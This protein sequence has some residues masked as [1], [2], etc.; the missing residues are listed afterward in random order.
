[1]GKKI[2]I[3]SDNNTGGAGVVAA[4]SKRALEEAGFICDFFFASQFFKFNP[5]RYL[6]NHKAQVLLRNKLN[7]YKPDFI[8]LHNYDNLFSPSILFELKK[9]KHRNSTPIIMTLHDY[10]V[11]SASNSLT[12][13]EKSKKMF[14]NELPNL[15][16]LLSKKLDKRSYIHGLARILQWYIY[17][18]IFKLD[19]EIDVFLCPSKFI[20]GFLIERIGKNKALFLPNPCRVDYKPIRKQLDVI[21]VTFAGKL[22]YEKG[23]Y[24]FLK[25]I[26]G[27]KSRKL[28]N[29]NIAGEGEYYDLVKSL[30]Y[31][32][33]KNKKLNVNINVLGRVNKEKL[34]DLLDIS[35]FILLPSLCYENSPLT[36][37]EGAYRS[38]RII[39]MNYGGMKEIGNNISGS[40]LLDRIDKD[41]VRTMLD[42]I[43]SRDD[44]SFTHNEKDMKFL[45]LYS[46]NLYSL[47]LFEVLRSKGNFNLAEK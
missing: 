21:N 26:E 12:Y 14:F 9:Y 8:M 22:Y 5:I 11:V 19:K 31:I 1:M 24:E 39:T 29:I 20:E 3:L 17:Y 42:E 15:Y 36:L 23:I 47:K 44:T 4:E 43:T 38:C 46:S 45:N 25:A 27:Y 40:I 34:I 10:H 37:I 33:N 30:A 28:I 32:I 35:H 6:Y 41:S 2:L 16:T 18:K 13:F 7:L